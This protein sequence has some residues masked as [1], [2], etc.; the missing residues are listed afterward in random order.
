MAINLGNFFQNM[1]VQNNNI[2]D[3]ANQVIREAANAVAAQD[4]A[5]LKDAVAQLKNLM[6]GDL[7]TGEI[8]KLQDGQVNINFGG[9]QEITASVQNPSTINQG[10]KLL[11]MVTSN[12]NN[13]ISLKV[14]DGNSQE[15]VMMNKA[16]SAAGMA[17]N[18]TTM[19]MVKTLLDNNM[20][21]DKQ[22]LNEL[23]RQMLKFPDASVDTLVRL[24][25]LSVPVTESNLIQF[26]A[27]RSYEH[28]ITGTL[29]QAVEAFS[30]LMEHMAS[31]GN[32]MEALRLFS[33]MEEILSGDNH[34]L[35]RDNTA[36][37][38]ANFMADE[39]M[40]IEVQ[41]LAVKVGE[42]PMTP[43]EFV[44]ELNLIF[45]NENFQN[46]NV[47]KEALSKLVSSKGFTRLFEEVVQKELLLTPEQ[48]AQ[49]EE[50]KDFYSRL[51]DKTRALT[52]ML[53]RGGEQTQ[54]LAKSFGAVRDNVN[55]MNDLS[56]NMTFM[57][58]PVKLQDGQA[59]GDL[60][61]YTNKKSLREHPEN[62]SAL[63]HL[64]MDHLGPM[65]IYVKMA[66]K[67]VSTNF[68]LESEEMLDFIYE[69]ID[70]LN[71]RIDRL[72]L[73]FQFTMN[74]KEDTGENEEKPVSFT[75]DF[76]D[77]SAPVISV[78]SYLF[79]SKA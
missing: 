8:T 19:T 30:G 34:T 31:D 63:L 54:N 70:E 35:I 4:G 61:V 21:I 47:P 38:L 59:Q 74:V 32:G 14:L 3:A 65:D 23:S 45:Q 39:E 7:F 76:L 57:Q 33:N 13:Q 77:K 52:D 53:Q 40:P 37:E 78:K 29:N 79:D 41:R 20:P 48:A 22:T 46:E 55:F 1:N 43:K 68:C 72:G 27:Y 75:E 62:I 11:F 15:M 44:K 26:E 2:Q 12:D 58:F 69:H 18:D 25:K 10:E 49:K 5:A 51:H 71:K 36:K 9:G 17:V 16:L 67:N 50:V 66:G 64:D 6:I 28:Q 73:N 24:N 60:Y 42:Q 56:Q